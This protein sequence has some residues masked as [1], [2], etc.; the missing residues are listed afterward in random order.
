MVFFIT[1]P[2]E[3][4]TM[5]EVIAGIVALV[6]VLGIL[7]GVPRTVGGGSGT[8]QWPDLLAGL[9]RGVEGWLDRARLL[10]VVIGVVTV[11][12]MAA[13]IMIFEDPS[14]VGEG[15]SLVAYVLG[16]V[17][18][19]GMFATAYLSVRRAGISS[20][21]ATFIGSVLS[22]IVLLLLITLLLID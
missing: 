16:L 11:L 2:L 6:V 22:G 18:F 19:V 20:A 14:I 7:F 17:G 8:R 9:E 1:P 10:D 12:V 5:F 13:A 15:G 3:S 21:E 4:A